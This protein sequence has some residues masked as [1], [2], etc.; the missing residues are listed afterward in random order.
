MLL[1][2]GRRHL[3]ALVVPDQEALEERGGGGGESNITCTHAPIPARVRAC[4]RACV[5][6]V[7]GG[8]GGGTHLLD[9]PVCLRSVYLGVG[10]RRQIVLAWLL[11][12]VAALGAQRS[13][14]S[15]R[16]TLNA[17][18]EDACKP[19]QCAC[20]ALPPSL[21]AGPPGAEEVRALV[22]AEIARA[23]V[24]RPGMERIHAFEVLQEPFRCETESQHCEQGRPVCSALLRAQMRAAAD[25]RAGLSRLHCLP[26][27]SATTWKAG[28]CS[29][30][31]PPS[32]S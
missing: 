18:K 5:C 27:P 4:V 29:L 6:G 2:S 10:S 28:C 14:P 16:A 21:A 25:R 12:H 30:L 9:Y 23:L 1:G 17:C 13:G 7:G 26:H 8:V 15:R 20:C 22:G 11:K 32:T 19:A 31:A 24:G 3:G